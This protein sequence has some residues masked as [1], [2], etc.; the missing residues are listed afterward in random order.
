MRQEMRA[1]LISTQ[2]SASLERPAWASCAKAGIR[3]RN[4]T[5]P[6]LNQAHEIPDDDGAPSGERIYF[7]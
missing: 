6:A 7:S 3:Y 1:G 4:G 5:V 2:A